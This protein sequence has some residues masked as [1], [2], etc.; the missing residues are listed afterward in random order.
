MFSVSLVSCVRGS[1]ATEIIATIRAK[2]NGAD[3]TE[4]TTYDRF[5]NPQTDAACTT[6]TISND[7]L[8]LTLTFDENSPTCGIFQEVLFV[9]CS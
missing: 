5:G 3:V 1:T 7:Y 9:P 2:I 8:Q 4:L 6:N